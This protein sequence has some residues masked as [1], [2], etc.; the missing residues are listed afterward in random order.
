MS[1]SLFSLLATKG[2][3]PVSVDSEGCSRRSSDASA[4]AESL[5]AV[6]V[7]GVCLGTR[8]VESICVWGRHLAVPVVIWRF[9]YV[10]EVVYVRDASEKTLME[11]PLCLG[12]DDVW[13]WTGCNVLWRP[14]R[15]YNSRH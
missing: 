13:R 2:T 4:S 5:C 1:S 7:A 10:W 15:H 12:A 6:T 8:E 11:A 9:V 14:H 3:N